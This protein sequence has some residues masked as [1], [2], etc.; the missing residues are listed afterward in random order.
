MTEGGRD[1]WREAPNLLSV[2]LAK[3][4]LFYEVGDGEDSRGSIKPSPLTEHRSQR[5][6]CTISK[7]TRSPRFGFH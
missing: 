4:S 6:T 5:Q 3:A 1:G 7:K 2:S